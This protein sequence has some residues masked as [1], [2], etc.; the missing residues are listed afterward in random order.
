MV[1]TRIGTY[2]Q[3]MALRDNALRQQD[4]LFDLNR[5]VSSGHVSHNYKGLAGDITR[6]NSSKSLQ[7]TKT[8][9]QK[10]I[11]FV[12]LRTE[13]YEFAMDSMHKSVDEMRKQVLTSMSAHNAEGLMASVN[14]N[15]SLMAQLVN[16]QENGQYVFSGSRTDVPPWNENFKYPES[17]LETKGAFANNGETLQGE[18]TAVTSTAKGNAGYT[19]DMTNCNLTEK[20]VG[21]II[22]ISF[23]GQMV[24]AQVDSV[25]SARTIEISHTH[26]ELSDLTIAAGTAINGGEIYKSVEDIVAKNIVG[27]N[28]LKAINIDDGVRL[29]YGVTAEPLITG[30]M[31]ALGRLVQYGNENNTNFAKSNPLKESQRRF[32]QTQL[33]DLATSMGKISIEETKNGLNQ[34]ILEDTKKRHKDELVYI[35]KVISE[36]Q[37]VDVAKAVSGVKLAEL[38]VKA[39]FSSLSRVSNLTLLDFM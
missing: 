4:Q 39:S 15:Y 1:V 35:K 7:T 20:N 12:E 21:S 38:A 31:Q 22:K 9:Y 16:T 3:N 29:E 32:L 26:P 17:F 11:D 25:A 24:T 30:A 28:K 5:Q 14:S 18:P 27:N 10:N 6:L 36:I 2:G 23:D 33:D 19:L 13:R 8:G 37:D 34:N